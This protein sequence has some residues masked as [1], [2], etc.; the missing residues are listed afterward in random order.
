[1]FPRG[2]LTVYPA[3]HAV[4][5]FTQ[6]SAQV[7]AQRYTQAKFMAINLDIE[8]GLLEAAILCE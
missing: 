5:I 8:N 4:A 1:M 7:F 2:T 6:C 3:G